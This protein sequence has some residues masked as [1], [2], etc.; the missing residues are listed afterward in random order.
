M[1]DL[2]SRRDGLEWCISA[3]L[4]WRGRL[5]WSS[6]PMWSNFVPRTRCS[7]RCCEGGGLS[8]YR[9]G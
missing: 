1:Q 7:T 6:S 5:I 4:L 9:V 2:P 3:M 8:S